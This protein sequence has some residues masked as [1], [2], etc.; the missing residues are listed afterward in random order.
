MPPV[1][2]SVDQFLRA[3]W[4]EGPGVAEL[5]SIGKNGVK[6]YPFSYPGS[7][8]SLVDAVPKHNREANVYMGVCLR[9]EPWPRK[10]GRLDSKGKEVVDFRGTEENAL[11]SNLV[12]WFEI[13]FTGM[14]HKMGAKTIS[15]DQAK[16]ALKE[17]PLKPSIILRSGGGIQG[18]FL[19]KEPVSGDDLWRLK[20]VNKAL[21]IYLGA[22]PAS[23]DLARILRV[24]GTMNVKYTPARPCEITWWHPEYA[25]TLD[26]FDFLPIENLLKPQAGE[27]APLPAAGHGPGQAPPTV[28]TTLPTGPSASTKPNPPPSIDLTEEQITKIGDLLG[29]IWV[30]GLKH[31]M[32]LCVAGMMVNRGVKVD[33][34]RGVVARASNKAGGDTDKRLKDVV[35]TYEAWY[36][37]HKVKGLT[38]LQTFIRENTPP[39]FIE[40]ALSILERVKKAL[41][42][43][44]KNPPGGGGGDDP[45]PDFKIAKIIKF[46]SR[47]ARWQVTLELENGEHHTATVETTALT[48]WPLFK[49]FFAEQTDEFLVG[50]KNVVWEGMLRQAKIDGLLEVRDTPRESRPEGA[51][52]SALGEFLG[53]AKENADV[54]MLKAFAGF[55]E[56]TQF[57]RFAALDNYLKNMNLRIDHRVIHHHLKNIGFE[58][59]TKRFGPK[60]VNVWIKKAL[61]GGGPNGN[62]HGQGN[63]HPQAPAPVQGPSGTSPGKSKEDAALDP[64]L[65]EVPQSPMSLPSVPTDPDEVDPFADDTGPQD[66]PGSRG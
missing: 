2:V 20:A 58:N 34:A 12:G 53:E 36:R 14:G 17:F 3:I 44:P 38:E 39:K 66:E 13:D 18:Y 49:D 23:V 31:E 43:P 45:D 41:P 4:G 47:P 42:K 55:D 10:T 60:T 64:T 6:A 65:F 51:I 57:F 54:G 37:N 24:P 7:L 28:N 1:S 19:G 33:S 16:K 5:T 27:Q 62:G 48:R 61:E 30:D 29:D 56:T 9:R 8:T 50:I 40:T 63:G 22:D 25:Y 46:N 35:S 59:T 21:A 11:S 26:D 32:A 52:D 15:E